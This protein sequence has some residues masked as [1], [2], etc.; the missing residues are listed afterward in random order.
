MGLTVLVVEGNRYL[1]NPESKA[2]DKECEKII[3]SYPPTATVSFDKVRKTDY[4]TF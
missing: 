3:S 2:A 4:R 1:I